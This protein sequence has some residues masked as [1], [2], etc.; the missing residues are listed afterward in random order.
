MKTSIARRTVSHASAM[1]SGIQTSW[2]MPVVSDRRSPPV[3]ARRD[4]TLLRRIR[5]ASRLPAFSTIR[6]VGIIALVLLGLAVL[7]LIGAEWP[8]LAARFGADA[9]AH[10][11]RR[12]RKAG[13]TVIEGRGEDDDF[14]A[15]VERD[16]A[17]LPVIEE[18]DD[19][20]RR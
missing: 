20:S 4:G 1:T 14:A 11:V 9:R 13:L 18:R 19:R 7:L 12:R 10:R 6:S 2:R 8:R 3:S 16:L 5:D 17:N 15:S